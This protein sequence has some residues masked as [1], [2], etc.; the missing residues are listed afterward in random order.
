MGF[1]PKQRLAIT[2]VIIKLTDPLESS[3][4]ADSRSRRNNRFEIDVSV[5][6]HNKRLE[7]SSHHNIP[8]YVTTSI[9]EAELKRAILDLGSLINI[10]SLSILDAVGVVR[11]SI[12]RQPIDV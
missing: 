7:L 3:G 4:I 5:F 10:V 8:L 1:S 9:R 11:S 12:Q 2:K 6:Y